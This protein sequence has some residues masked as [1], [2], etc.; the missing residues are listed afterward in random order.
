MHSESIV[1]TGR[2]PGMTPKKL[3]GI[4]GYPLGHSLSP[5]LHNFGFEAKGIE[6]VYMAFSVAPEDLARAIGGVRA[7]PVS[8]ASVTI[9]HKISVMEYLDDLT[10][11][12]RVVGAVNTLDWRGGRLFGDNTDVAGVAAPLRL[13]EGRF[14]RVLV[15]GAGGAA[16]ACLAALQ[17]LE[18]PEIFVTNRNKAR[19]ENLAKDFG[20]SLLRWSER[21]QQF[22]LFINS[23]P[24]GMLGENEAQSPLEE[25]VLS[26]ESTVF[27]LVYNPLETKLIRQAE[28]A[29]AKAIS[30]LEMFLHQGLEQFRLWTGERLDPEAARR[31]LAAALGQ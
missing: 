16:R 21:N 23:T 17:E 5:L 27:D 6:S 10:D 9:P 11:R 29:G 2:Q 19:A 8:G 14:K 24:L 3:Y 20:C 25:G 7:L 15:L 28:S 30:G 18:I 13:T 12:A 22:D 1:S 26:P 31:K 4:F